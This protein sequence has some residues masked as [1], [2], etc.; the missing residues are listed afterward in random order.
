MG[1]ETRTM[2]VALT[3][4]YGSRD[5]AGGLLNL[6]HS[7]RLVSYAVARLTRTEFRLRAGM[8]AVCFR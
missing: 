7:T 5:T 1:V 6:A 2:E 4:N 3:P 8:T